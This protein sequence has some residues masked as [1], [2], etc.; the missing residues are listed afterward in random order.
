MR[1]TPIPSARFVVPRSEAMTILD[2]TFAQYCRLVD[3][4]D[5]VAE[6]HGNRW[7]VTVASIDAL[8]ARWRGDPPAAA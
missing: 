5:L 8:A 4:G 1:P 3:A 7:F 2:V 6:Q